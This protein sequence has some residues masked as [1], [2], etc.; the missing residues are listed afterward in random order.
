MGNSANRFDERL[1][2][3]WKRFERQ[4]EISERLGALIFGDILYQ[5][6]ESHRKYHA[7]KHP[8]LLLDELQIA[9]RSM[10]DWF[11]NP[12][13]DAA[14]TLALFD[15]DLFYDPRATD[16]EER[17]AG[18]ALGHVHYLK[19]PERVGELA[20]RF[21]L[22]TKHVETPTELGAMIVCDI[23]LSL[24]GASWTSFAQDSRDIR[25]E[26]AHVSDADFRRGRRDF[27]NGMLK[28]PRIYATNHFYGKFEVTARENME[29]ALREQ[30][31][32]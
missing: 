7:V 31:A 29:R 21:I 24:M 20:N 18:G 28:R 26:Y 17:S 10:P 4:F 32:H 9:R 30:F 22:A 1:L 23:D 5:Y 6:D 15:H 13:Q 19:L 25:D 3:H 16:N 8:V 2:E 12:M 11:A 14:I 27:L